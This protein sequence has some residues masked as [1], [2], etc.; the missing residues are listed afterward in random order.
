MLRTMRLLIE[1]RTWVLIVD[2]LFNV[3]QLWGGH[4]VMLVLHI[5]PNLTFNY[6]SILWVGEFDL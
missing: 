2:C 4:N 3:G 5:R 6:F 1:L